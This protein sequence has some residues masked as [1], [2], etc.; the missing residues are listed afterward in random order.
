MEEWL[1]DSTSEERLGLRMIWA[2]VEHQGDRKFKRKPA[3]FYSTRA[4][5][6]SRRT[7]SSE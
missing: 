4:G 3:N 2:I 7:S 1:R 6:S 5:L